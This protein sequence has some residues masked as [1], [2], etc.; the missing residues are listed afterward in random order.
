MKRASLRLLDRCEDLELGFPGP[1]DLVREVPDDE[2]A[3]LLDELD[4]RARGQPDPEIR[5]RYNNLVDILK[6]DI[7]RRS[8][9][10][11]KDRQQYL[12]SL[13]RKT[14]KETCE[15]GERHPRGANF[16]V[17]AIDGRKTI[18]LSG[19]YPTHAEA[20][21]RVDEIRELAIKMDPGAAFASFGTT[22]M[23]S[24]YKKRG[25]LDG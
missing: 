20:V 18:P 24:S 13:A 8:S 17:T 12:A 9:N 16:Y 6:K 25:V 21:A 11:K 2:V 14:G 19:P 5:R 4:Y 23:K 10:T 7:E 3:A 1:L 15:C 22:A